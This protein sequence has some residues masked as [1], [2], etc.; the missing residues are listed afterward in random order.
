MVRNEAIANAQASILE[1]FQE[2]VAYPNNICLPI[3]PEAAQLGVVVNADGRLQGEP[4]PLRSTGYAV[5]D[6]RAK[7]LVKDFEFPKAATSQAYVVVV[8]TA[9]NSVNCQPLT[10]Q[11]FDLISSHSILHGASPN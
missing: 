7:A 8:Q 9:Y 5:F 2:R 6:D 1:D 3:E 4:Q 11:T 10:S